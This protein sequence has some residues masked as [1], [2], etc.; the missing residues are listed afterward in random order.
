[1]SEGSGS[2]S[3]SE[4][5]SEGRR[6]KGGRSRRKKLTNENQGESNTRK[7]NKLVKR[8]S[9]IWVKLWIF[10]GRLIIFFVSRRNQQK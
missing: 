10:T 6:E 8:D 9:K 4:E 1:V 2:L 3:L 7:K 5:I